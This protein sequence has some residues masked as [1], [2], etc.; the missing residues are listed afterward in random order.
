MLIANGLNARCPVSPPEQGTSALV[1]H[2]R[3]NRNSRLWTLEEN[4]NEV[5]LI[6]IKRIRINSNN[7]DKNGG[8]NNYNY[9]NNCTLFCVKHIAC[10]S[11]SSKF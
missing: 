5:M 1:D 6:I 10:P 4:D 3:L 2:A 8:N 11:E 7:K 9:N